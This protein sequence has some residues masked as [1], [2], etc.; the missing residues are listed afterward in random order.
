ME[1]AVALSARFAAKPLEQPKYSIRDVPKCSKDL[2]GSIL[3]EITD[4]DMFTKSMAEMVL[5]CNEVT[6][7]RDKT[8]PARKQENLK[9]TTKP[10]SLEYMADSLD[11]DDP[12]FGFIVRTKR[13]PSNPNLSQEQ[14]LKFQEGMMQG[15]ITVT[16]FTNYQRTFRWDSMH[17]SA[18]SYDEPDI[19][20]QMASRRRKVDFDGSLSAEMQNTVRCGD[21]WNEG[22]VFPHIAEISL[23]G[24]LG[25]GRTLVSLAIERLEGMQSIGNRNYDYVALQ[26]TKNSVQFYETMGFVRVGAITT[27][28]NFDKKQKAKEKENSSGTEN[29]ES[30]KDSSEPKGSESDESVF[31]SKPTTQITTTKMGQTPLSLSKQY[32][33]NVWDIIFL[34]RFTY[35][36]IEPRSWLKK[37]IQL[38]C[39]DP[40]KFDGISNA[41]H[42]KKAAIKSS[43]T[44]WYLAANNETP[45][46]IAE[47]INVPC[48]CLI[49][50]NRERF[51]DL[52]PNSRLMPRTRIQVSNLST[53]HDNHVPYCHWTFPDDDF[54]SNEPSYMMARRLNRRK[55]VATKL[56][57]FESS[58]RA[59][60]EKY[61]PK[62]T[63]ANEST[64]RTP[65]VNSR[66]N[67]SHAQME[68]KAVKT[69]EKHPDKP[70]PPK[71]P[72]TAYN[73]YLDV[74]RQKLR[75]NNQK[76]STILLTMNAAKK[77]KELTARG[78]KKYE[79]QN[80]EAKLKYQDL[81]KEYNRKL[82]KFRILHP[83]SVD[84]NTK[85]NIINP[86]DYFDKVVTLNSDGQK[87]AGGEFKYYYVLTFI[88]DLFWC[89]LA[90]LQRCGSFDLSRP[91]SQG[92]PKWV[93]VGENE[94]KEVDISAS[95]C[96]IVES[97]ATTK[98]PDADDERWDILESGHGLVG[99]ESNDEHATSVCAKKH[100]QLKCK[101]RVYSEDDP[102]EELA[103][104]S[105]TEKN[106]RA[107]RSVGARKK[108]IKNVNMQETCKEEIIQK[109]KRPRKN[110]S[111]VST[112]ISSRDTSNLNGTKDAEIKPKTSK[113]IR[114]SGE[115]YSKPTTD[116]KY[117]KK[118][119]LNSANRCLVPVSVL[120]AKY[121]RS[122]D[123][124]PT[125]N[126]VI[127]EGKSTSEGSKNNPVLNSIKPTAINN[128]ID[129]DNKGR[130]ERKRKAKSM[131]Q[132][133]G[134]ASLP[135]SDYTDKIVTLNFDGQKEA[136]GECRYYYV[137]T[138]IPYLA[139]CRLAPMR[140]CGVF[141][142]SRPQSQ[143]RP[144]WVL[145]D[146]D[147]A[148]ELDMNARLCKIVD[149][150]A[151]LKCT[152][153]DNERW[154]ILESGRPMA[155]VGSSSHVPN[156]RLKVNINRVHVSL[157]VRGLARRHS[158]LKLK[159]KNAVSKE[160]L[161]ERLPYTSKTSTELGSKAT[162]DRSY[163]KESAL[164]SFTRP[165]D[166]DEKSSD[167]EPTVD[168]V[169]EENRSSLEGAKDDPGLNS[170]HPYT[171]NDSVNWNN[172]GREKRKRKAKSMSQNKGS[173]RPVT[174]YN[175]HGGVQE[176]VVSK[177]SVSFIDD[178][179]RSSDVD[180]IEYSDSAYT[181]LNSSVSPRD[182]KE[183]SRKISLT[184][185]NRPLNFDDK[186]KHQ[187]NMEDEHVQDREDTA[188][189]SNKTL[190]ISED[191]NQTFSDVSCEM[192]AKECETKLSPNNRHMMGMRKC[193]TRLVL[194]TPPEVKQK[195]ITSFFH[196]MQ[197]SGS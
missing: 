139:R 76:V 103:H 147:K 86:R 63:S 165:L 69:R 191:S 85:K 99:P 105:R 122:S 94:G 126:K 26:A 186:G 101:K 112:T 100:K 66:V 50:A 55:G 137:L 18:F 59:P 159:R 182:A 125:V 45:K 187:S 170:I 148:T 35:P 70:I 2:S 60:A 169:I 129:L 161:T 22:V 53:H 37:G 40:I 58:L 73:V 119:V 81:L 42:N 41:S 136:G 19:A 116:Q 15:F 95:V 107:R 193:T 133:K 67:Q 32:N 79:E 8:K 61:D 78:R 176:D 124:K 113:R 83:G 141:G 177:S 181:R 23:L 140:S 127:Q 143:G 52:A 28:E 75:A 180:K 88:P 90:P 168:K 71:R 131:S 6:R 7:R 91:Q 145:V 10:L 17:D 150:V 109:Q 38:V 154:D 117:I 12:L 149:S 34:N 16:T 194:H 20:E 65:L 156:E 120:P 172:K 72:K 188:S 135:I 102:T 110:P 80:K 31:V 27:D 123:T 14:R 25:C 158:K 130:E 178:S 54:E 96:E 56:K 166:K 33:V 121:E 157:A 5:L 48:K 87:E 134:I 128:S 97:V 118:P 164:N 189:L 4:R 46:Q 146:G 68:N 64:I 155:T 24:G 13:L 43:A 106:G 3:Q 98:C 82:E 104:R 111:L 44:Q 51:Q 9:K 57:P 179:T 1:G 108:L 115:L 93:L 62:P 11:V 77:W 160:A 174:L 21:V 36:T 152:D 114:H 74:E 185:S 89:H 196:C 167:T 84:V 162:T 163:M 49:A 190:F 132:N 195:T 184:S 92:R 151:T 142:R 197:K 144:I 138:Y 29:D 47:K 39:P 183:G 171:I 175:I 173:T 30:E 192:A 153:A